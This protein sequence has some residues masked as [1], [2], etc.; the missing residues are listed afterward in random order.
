MLN[1]KNENK[2]SSPNNSLNAFNP[3]YKAILKAELNM[4]KK[5]L[6]FLKDDILKDVRKIVKFKNKSTKYFDFR[7]I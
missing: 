2:S 6:L 4:M 1:I 5:D 7:T 3:D